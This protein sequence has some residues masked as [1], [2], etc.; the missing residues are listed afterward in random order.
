[1]RV[2]VYKYE[3]ASCL[4][5]LLK[6]VV[7]VYA[8]VYVKSGTNTLCVHTQADHQSRGKSAVK[9]EQSGHTVKSFMAMYLNKANSV[10]EHEGKGQSPPSAA[11]YP[12]HRAEKTEPVKRKR[13][14]KPRV[15][16]VVK[17]PI[18]YAPLKPTPV[19]PRQ[20]PPR[21]VRTISPI[22]YISTYIFTLH[23]PQIGP[24]DRGGVQTVLNFKSPDS[25]HNR[26]D[27][28]SDG[29]SSISVAYTRPHFTET[30]EPPVLDFNN[31]ALPMEADKFVKI[32]G[33]IC[34]VLGN[35]QSGGAQQVLFKQM[36]LP[37]KKR[38]K[39][40][41]A[42]KS[43]QRARRSGSAAGSQASGRTLSLLSGE[44][45]D[46]DDIDDE[47][48]CGEV[49]DLE[50]SDDEEE[51]D[52][53][54][55]SH[56][57][58]SSDDD[59]IVDDDKVEE[60]SEDEEYAESDSCEETPKNEENVSKMDDEVSACE[61][62]KE[63][64]VV[65][66]AESD[67]GDDTESEKDVKK[68]EGGDVDEPKTEEP[69]EIQDSP[70]DGVLRKRAVSSEAASCGE[71]SPPESKKRK[72]VPDEDYDDLL[73][74]VN[75]H[76]IAIEKYTKHV[77]GVKEDP[78]LKH[79]RRV[80]KE[81]KRESDEESSQ[82][83]GEEKK[84][85][86]PVHDVSDCDDDSEI[87][88]DESAEPIKISGVFPTT[89]PLVILDIEVD[90]TTNKCVRILG[91]HRTWMEPLTRKKLTAGL[92]KLGLYSSGNSYALKKFQASGG[93]VN[94]AFTRESIL[95]ITDPQY[96]WMC[97]GATNTDR[98]MAICSAIG[99][100]TYDCIH[101][102][103]VYAESIASALTNTAHYILFPE[104]KLPAMSTQAGLC[105]VSFSDFLHL[106][107]IKK[108]KYDYRV[109]YAAWSIYG[110]MQYRLRKYGKSCT[111]LD[112]IQHDRICV[113]G[114][115][116]QRAIDALGI[117]DEKPHEDF[118]HA[119]LMSKTV[120]LLVHGVNCATTILGVIGL[121]SCMNT[122]KTLGEIVGKLAFEKRLNTVGVLP[123]CLSTTAEATDARVD[124]T[125]ALTVM[126][127][128]ML[129]VIVGPEET[130]GFLYPLMC[131][132]VEEELKRP[133]SEVICVVSFNQ[134]QRFFP[135]SFH[136][137]STQS[138]S[139]SFVPQL[140]RQTT[141]I[142][143]V[144]EVHHSGYLALSNLLAMVPR[145]CKVVLVGDDCCVP[146]PQPKTDFGRPFD[147]MCTTDTLEPNRKYVSAH[148]T[149][150]TVEQDVLQAITDG[151]EDHCTTDCIEI[152]EFDLSGSSVPVLGDQEVDIVLVSS[153]HT[154]KLAQD[155]KELLPAIKGAQAKEM[156]IFTHGDLVTVKSCGNIIAAGRVAC[157]RSGGDRILSVAKQMKQPVQR[158]MQLGGES[159]AVYV[160][161]ELLVELTDGSVPEALTKDT[162]PLE[163]LIVGTT[164]MTPM[165]RVPVVALILDAY[166]TYT[167]IITASKMAQKRLILLQQPCLGQ[168]GRI[169]A[170]VARRTKDDSLMHHVI[171]AVSVEYSKL[172]V[173]DKPR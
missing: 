31:V 145:W 144:M 91:F 118:E 112:T 158:T 151:I 156:S 123:R 47:D 82:H 69:D 96:S 55:E 98:E 32:R 38:K 136:F 60:Q 84:D 54:R 100:N 53:E 43:A 16:K 2:V 122:E 141:K 78:L 13:P 160:N 40:V 33:Y 17:S 71:V 90:K 119:E 20:P 143:L 128:N 21:Q 134:R 150:G 63:L 89:C 25:G 15:K 29:Q 64:E 170:A 35:V 88:C 163:H 76:D 61:S 27:N 135:G 10:V 103:K 173:K 75:V 7:H 6:Y 110:I 70:E 99:V 68:E 149:K 161:T 137:Y 36:K 172:A 87:K 126:D 105:N 155:C 57:S 34:R 169:N 121:R 167:D 83:V 23:S 44:S 162:F 132:A 117:P 133:A 77:S 8:C 120:T 50:Y 79:S 72:S 168:K 30:V 67:N 166:T 147:V 116:K 111:R 18:R 130:G 39:G 148:M 58:K 28:N 74:S 65:A 56:E 48:A 26:T 37:E 152:R 4:N 19:Q 22:L 127:D 113:P 97:A 92:E 66:T 80:V 142:L 86:S 51:S 102:R 59:F 108:Y 5:K 52:E 109:L 73:G 157:A 139:C 3:T 165:V 11:P 164:C 138:E 115:L 124:V 125:E 153:A 106:P 129:S 46:I 94:D 12:I 14:S 24:Q 49:V 146:P 101:R 42:P 140:A 154:R 45:N 1:M 95:K 159:G 131:R 104:E 9:V 93:K 62:E 85:S 81:D 107:D 41:K 171:E 114:Y